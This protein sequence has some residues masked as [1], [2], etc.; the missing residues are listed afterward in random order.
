MLLK[1]RNINFANI[2]AFFFTIFVGVSVSGTAFEAFFKNS[3][4]VTCEKQKGFRFFTF[5]FYC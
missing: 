4:T 2:S 5:F 3:S 1:L